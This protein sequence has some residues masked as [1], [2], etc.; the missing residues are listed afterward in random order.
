MLFKGY[1]ILPEQ[2]LL[3][4]KIIYPI[5]YILGNT[6]KNLIKANKIK[7]NGNLLSYNSQKIDSS[8]KLIQIPIP[9]INEIMIKNVMNDELQ[10]TLDIIRK[11]KID[12]PADKIWIKIKLK[13]LYRKGVIICINEKDE[14]FWKLKY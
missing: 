7:K 3:K 9:R 4:E 5:E 14:L 11:L 2:F 6:I 1:Y 13:E 8:R 12:V 10:T